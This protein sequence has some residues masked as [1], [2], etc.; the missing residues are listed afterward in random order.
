MSKTLASLFAVVLLSAGLAGYPA[1]PSAAPA[2]R[3]AVPPLGPSEIDLTTFLD[4]NNI[5]MGVTNLGNFAGSVFGP[6]VEFPKGSGKH[7]TYASGAW[8]GAKV[9]GEIRVALGIYMPEFRPGCIYPDGTYDP[10]DDP[11]HH[12]YKIVKGDTLSPDYTDW[13]DE[14]GAPVGPDGK[15]LLI[16]EQTLWCVYHDANPG[17]HQAQEGGTLPLGIEVQQTAFAFDWQVAFGKVVF[18]EFTVINRLTDTLDSAYFGI[19]CDPDVGTYSDDLVGC[20]PALDLGFGYNADN[21]DAVY[22][23]QPPCVGYDLLK[24]PVDD[25]GNQM[26]MMSFR[27]YSMTQDPANYTESYN[28]LRGLA[29]DGS[30]IIDPTTG[31][32]TT[33]E[34][35]GDPVARTG[36]IDTQVGDRRFVMAAGP[37]TMEPGDTQHV[38]LAVIVGQGR[39]RLVSVKIMKQLDLVAQAAYDAGFKG[40][41]LPI[42]EGRLVDPDAGSPFRGDRQPVGMSAGRLETLGACGCGVTVACSPSWDCAALGVRVAQ[43]GSYLLQVIDTRGRLVSTIYEGDLSGGAQS[44]IWYGRDNSGRAVPAGIYFAH[45]ASGSGDVTGSA[46]IVLLR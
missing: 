40:Q 45:L 22:G 42:G 7:C 8:I 43:P 24:G 15:P 25:Y 20:D 29:V 9:N 14:F 39:N 4:A 18:T 2:D 10:D 3:A 12:V 27:A 38:A 21:S 17:Y 23:A 1:Q 34:F 41:F 35:S 32:P 31:N 37:F 30:A 5:S 28:L 11:R 6:G 44:F 36:W 26:P 16:G 33:F 19:F 13:P 46:K